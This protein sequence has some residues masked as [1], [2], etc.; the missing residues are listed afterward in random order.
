MSRLPRSLGYHISYFVVKN[1]MKKIRFVF[2]GISLTIL[3]ICVMASSK[4]DHPPA[5]FNPRTENGFA[6]IELFTSQG[7]SSCPPA[8]EILANYANQ[9]NDRII[10]LSF[11]VDYWNRLGWIDLFSS[12]K[13][14]E[15]QK[16]YAE[17]FNLESVYTPQII[18]NGQ[19]QWVGSDDENISGSVKKFLKENNTTTINLSSINNTAGKLTIAYSVKD[20]GAN[21]S[22]N[23]ALV[24]TK[25][26]TKIKA[27]ENR[28]ADLTNHNVVRDFI[29]MPLSNDATGNC[30]LQM[31]NGSDV[32]DYKLV[33]FV[34]QNNSGKITGAIQSKL[35]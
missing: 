33:L 34:Q 15:R 25:A 28:G 32:K 3:I 30:I 7:C 5:L 10:P 13:Y 12:S 17:K 24:L 26:T 9:N 11:H 14:S 18:I 2:S 35:P 22:I 1:G 6:V 23:A 20:P 4:R 31:P 29:S 27:G 16:V 8:D 21:T 19:S